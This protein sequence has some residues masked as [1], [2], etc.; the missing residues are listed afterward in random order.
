LSLLDIKGFLPVIIQA[1]TRAVN[2]QQT[3]ET[4]SQYENEQGP[5]KIE[6]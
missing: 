3:D 4:D 1:V 5:V 6:E 2:V